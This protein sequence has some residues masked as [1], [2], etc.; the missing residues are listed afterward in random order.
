[1]KALSV[2]ALAAFFVG[3]CESEPTVIDLS[4]WLDPDPPDFSPEF[5]VRGTLLPLLES[6]EAQGL[7]RI[8]QRARAFLLA[9][10]ALGANSGSLT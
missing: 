5:T 2:V 8:E 6:A 9:P 1:M 7:G 3:A 10:E 4:G